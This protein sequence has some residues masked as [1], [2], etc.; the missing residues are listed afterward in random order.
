MLEAA[1]R[2]RPE[3]EREG[4]RGLG[5]R[6][7]SSFSFPG[8]SS[9]KRERERERRLKEVY[10]QSSQAYSSTNRYSG[11]LLIHI[12]KTIELTYQRQHAYLGVLFVRDQPFDGESFSAFAYASSCSM[13]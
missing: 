9:W 10:V 4:G 3:R 8:R 1:S 2:R 5:E 6:D 13:N 7:E 11:S 12:S